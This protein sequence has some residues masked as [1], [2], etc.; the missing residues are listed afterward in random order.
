[1][2]N[3]NLKF[4]G[5]A[6]GDTPVTLDVKI[7]GVTVFSNAVSTIPGD[8][9]SNTSTIVC[10]QVLFEINDTSLFPTTFSGA[11][12]HSV[13]VSGGTGVLLGQI[14]SNYMP[15]MD[16]NTFIMGNAVNFRPVFQGGVPTNSEGTPDSRS[17][18]YLDGIQ[19]VSQ[20][21]VSLGEWSWVILTGSNLSC[22]LNISEGND[23]ITP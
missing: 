1:M 20:C 2:N 13:E 9:P 7:D 10:D 19:Q 16:G 4:Y 8:I 5:F 15:S 23:S 17:S 22:N 12:T 6:Y 21:D 18:V 14:Q 3:R 11:Y